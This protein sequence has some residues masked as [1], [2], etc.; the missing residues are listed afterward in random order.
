MSAAHPGGGTPPTGWGAAGAEVAGRAGDEVAVLRVVVDHMGGMP[1]RGG[2]EPGA[3]AVLAGARQLLGEL[4]ADLLVGGAVPAFG[5]RASRGRAA[6]VGG[7][8]GRAAGCATGKARAQ[9]S[10]H[11]S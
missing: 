11:L 9:Q 1:G 8:A 4:G 6:G 2:G 10:C 5:G 7:A 3:A